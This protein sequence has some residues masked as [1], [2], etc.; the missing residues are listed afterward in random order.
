MRIEQVWETRMRK[1]FREWQA[2]RVKYSEV[3]EAMECLARTFDECDKESTRGGETPVDVRRPILAVAQLEKAIEECMPLERSMRYALKAL[4]GIEYDKALPH[5]L[6]A[7]DMR[8]TL[9]EL[10]VGDA[11]QL[12]GESS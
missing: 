4:T 10:A 11:A 12:G 1:L 7:E 5:V 9:S 8:S 2:L 3:G 6:E